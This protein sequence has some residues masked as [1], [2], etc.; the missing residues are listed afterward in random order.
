MGI[1]IDREAL[2]LLEAMHA[3]CHV[4]LDMQFK[5]S[6]SIEHATDGAPDHDPTRQDV[7]RGEEMEM[8]L[9]TGLLLIRKGLARRTCTV[10]SPTAEGRAIAQ[11]TVG[12]GIAYSFGGEA[13]PI[14]V[15]P[16]TSHEI[17]DEPLEVDTLASMPADSTLTIR[18]SASTVA[19]EVTAGAR[20]LTGEMSVSS[21]RAIVAFLV[22]AGKV[23]SPVTA[24][25]GG[26]A[27]T[28][29]HERQPLSVRLTGE[30]DF[31][32]V[33]FRAPMHRIFRDVLR[34]SLKADGAGGQLEPVEIQWMSFDARGCDW[35]DADEGI[36]WYDPDTAPSP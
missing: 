11:A 17:V 3:G 4:T 10:L 14:E 27:L 5:V 26:V 15:E 13:A 34:E 30:F 16:S 9:R 8:P 2:T 6:W 36:D 33:T 18:R 35:E 21:A 32:D 29:A 24:R 28:L 19:L 7:W 25:F 31:A 22:E 1:R 12:T 20:R 23:S